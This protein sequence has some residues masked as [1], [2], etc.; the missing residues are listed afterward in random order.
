[1]KILNKKLLAGNYLFHYL[2]LGLMVIWSVVF[3]YFAGVA[4]VEALSAFLLALTYFFWGVSYH[5]IHK[6][7]SL[8]CVVE[9]LIM[10]L[11]GFI[12]LSFVLV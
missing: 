9:Y 6:T 4:I 12:I 2:W 8:K 3:L 5:Y 10:A 1:M 7:L 11:I